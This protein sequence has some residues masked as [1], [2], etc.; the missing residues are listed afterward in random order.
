MFSITIF[1]FCYLLLPCTTSIKGPPK[2]ANKVHSVETSEITSNREEEKLKDYC[3]EENKNDTCNK[4]EETEE[5]TVFSDEMFG[6][7]NASLFVIVA[8]GRLGNHLIA[9]SVIQALAHTLHIRPLITKE[10]KIF[11]QKYFDVKHNIAVL[12]ETFCN[13]QQIPFV[14]FEGSI[15]E[16]A[17]NKQYHT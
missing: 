12:E 11:L 6:P 3:N 13:Y 16:L 15:D 17:E 1:V 2:N 8:K 9:Y 7:Q 10:T 14:Q 4:K 5:C